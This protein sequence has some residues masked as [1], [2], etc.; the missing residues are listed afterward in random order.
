MPFD[1][2]ETELI[3]DVAQAESL[4]PADRL[5]DEVEEARDAARSYLTKTRNINIRLSEYDLFCL[6]R[7]SAKNNIPYQTIL[8]S[9]I[10]QYVT[11]K[12]KP[13]L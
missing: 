1:P 10:H 9:V 4:E 2:Y 5:E 6:K 13:Q 11:G 7:K 12:I 8:A 3:N